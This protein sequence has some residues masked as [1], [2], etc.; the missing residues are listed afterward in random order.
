MFTSPHKVFRPRHAYLHKPGCHRL[1]QVAL[2]ATDTPEMPQNRSHGHWV[3]TLEQE[4]LYWS[5]ALR[6][7]TAKTLSA[8]SC[9]IF[10]YIQGSGIVGGGLGGLWPFGIKGKPA[11]AYS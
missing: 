1:A 6:L 7:E 4:G 10:G 2:A 9:D 8:R 5:V 11:V 3:P